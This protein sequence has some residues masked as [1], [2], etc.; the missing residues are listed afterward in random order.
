MTVT[1]LT[2]TGVTVMP[3]TD[4]GDLYLLVTPKG[5]KW[6]RLDYR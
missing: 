5:G 2:A 4:G 1:L 3:L 6:W